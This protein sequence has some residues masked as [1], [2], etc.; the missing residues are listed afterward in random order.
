MA[1]WRQR[2]TVVQ[3]R[4]WE[5]L[6][7]I[8]T[9]TMWWW[10]NPRF[11]DGEGVGSRRVLTN[12]RRSYRIFISDWK[13]IR[14]P[15]VGSRMAQRLCR[16]TSI[17]VTPVKPFRKTNNGKIQLD[18]TRTRD[19]SYDTLSIRRTPYADTKVSQL[20]K[21]PSYSCDVEIQYLKSLQ[22]K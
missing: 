2:R 15:C 21:W 5:I 4:P 3:S 19:Q 20:L 12:P 17:E 22:R 11:L 16:P 9:S 6:P 14:A 1:R 7:E 18:R 8:L 13:I 10:D